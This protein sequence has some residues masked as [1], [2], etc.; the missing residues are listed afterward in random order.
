RIGDV[1]SVV[2]LNQQH[3]D[4]PGVVEWLLFPHA[5]LA[6]DGERKFWNVFRK[7]AEGKYTS[8]RRVRPPLQIKGFS[9]FAFVLSKNPVLRPIFLK[10]I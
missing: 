7:Y 4:V 6:T 5:A 3:L 8:R 1:Y 10:P 2:R 9:P